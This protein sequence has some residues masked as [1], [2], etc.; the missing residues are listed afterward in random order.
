VSN[1]YASLQQVVELGESDMAE[2]GVKKGLRS[3]LRRLIASVSLP[4]G[5]VQLFDCD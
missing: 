3:T 1:G 4:P 2:I 5:N